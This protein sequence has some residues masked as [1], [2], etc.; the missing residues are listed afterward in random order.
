MNLSRIGKIRPHGALLALLAA[1]S[2]LGLLAAITAPATGDDDWPE[3]AIIE[4]PGEFQLPPPEPD[5]SPSPGPTT[6]PSPTAPPGNE[7]GTAVYE[8]VTVEVWEISPPPDPSPSP[9]VPPP[10]G[11]TAAVA[12]QV[13]CNTAAVSASGQNIFRATL[14]TY[15]MEVDWCWNGAR[16]TSTA[17]PRISGTVAG[18]AAA[19]GWNYE[20]VRNMN[21]PA[22]RFGNNWVYRTYSQGAFAFSPPPRVWTIQRVYPQLWIDVDGAGA[23][24]AWAA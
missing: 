4:A 8:V 11:P 7:D 19:L 13:R 20:G 5:P 24:R 14:W 18:F 1:I 3:G 17:G 6:G 22:D 9:T 21:G 23:R 15:R 2:T 10:T 16:V 12:Q